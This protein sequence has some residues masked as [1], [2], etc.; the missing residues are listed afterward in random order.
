VRG[1]ADRG[2]KAI[3]PQGGGRE[4]IGTGVG[5]GGLRSRKKSYA[6]LGWSQGG[7]QRGLQRNKRPGARRKTERARVGPEKKAGARER[8]SVSRAIT[9]GEEKKLRKDDRKNS[10]WEHDGPRG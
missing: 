5:Q 10:V 8:Q 3:T 4:K 9:R 1:R 7:D 6:R 2:E